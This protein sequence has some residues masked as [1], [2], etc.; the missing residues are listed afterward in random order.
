MT[1]AYG[2]CLLKLSKCRNHVVFSARCKR[3]GLVPQSLMIKSPVNSANGWRIARDTGDRFL[4][5]RLRLS[6][7]KFRRLEEERKKRELDLR[8]I[9]SGAD[10]DRLVETSRAAAERAFVKVREKQRGKFVRQFERMR[11]KECSSKVDKSKWV[12][13]LST[14]ELMKEER[15]VLERGM[16]FAPA[17]KSIPRMDIVAKVEGAISCAYHVEKEEA[18]RARAAVANVIKHTKL[19]K[20]NIRKEEWEAVSNLE[21]DKNIIVLE[22]DKGNVTVVMDVAGYKEKAMEVI[23]K[24]PF[25]VLTKYPTKR[26]E[27]RVNGELKRFAAEWKHQQGN[28]GVSETRRR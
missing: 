2:K 13:N 4:N 26:N 16:K 19:P 17:P 27:K 5:E 15:A 9:P 20:A 18:E 1:C 10:Y 6:N 25:K 21:K 3:S 12:I 24:E 22:A 8:G 28:N 7:Q 23:G 14:R 11:S